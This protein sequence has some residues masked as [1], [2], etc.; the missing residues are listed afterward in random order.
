MGTLTTCVVS[1]L[2]NLVTKPQVS[3]GMGV[4]SGGLGAGDTREEQLQ[5]CHP[6]PGSLLSVQELTGTSLKH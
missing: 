6:R 5:V 3:S 1:Y 4:R 2:G